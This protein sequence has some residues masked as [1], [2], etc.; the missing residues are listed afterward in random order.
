MQKRTEK[1]A[2]KDEIKQ[3]FPEC[4]LDYLFETEEGR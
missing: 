4:T 2:F 3:Q 1:V